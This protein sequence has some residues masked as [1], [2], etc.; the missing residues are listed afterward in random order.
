MTTDRDRELSRR[1]IIQF[2]GIGAWWLT[3]QQDSLAAATQSSSWEAL[4]PIG[5]SSFQVADEIKTLDMSM[6]SYADIKSAKASVEN[7]EGLAVPTASGSGQSKST[8]IMKVTNPKARPIVL[9]FPGSGKEKTE[10][11][12]SM[13]YK[14]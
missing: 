13:E 1:G 6:P 12:G 2:F 14:F 9:Q 7:V 4:R 5:S 10:T 11:K 3:L 8:S